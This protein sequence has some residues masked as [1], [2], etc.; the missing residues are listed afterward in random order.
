LDHALADVV[1]AGVAEHGT[2][3]VRLGDAPPA[4]ADVRAEGV[5]IKGP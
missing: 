3:R 2:E 4:A 5:V 1:G